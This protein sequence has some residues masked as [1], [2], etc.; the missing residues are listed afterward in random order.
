MSLLIPVESLR[1]R[2]SNEVKDTKF[3]F[4]GYKISLA[5]DLSYSA[6]YWSMLESYRNIMVKG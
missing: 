4:H 6:L 5:R 1:I 3:N 2:L